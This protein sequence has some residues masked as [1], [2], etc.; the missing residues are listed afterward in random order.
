MYR[1]RQRNKGEAGYDLMKDGIEFED[2]KYSALVQRVQNGV[3]AGQRLAVEA[4]EGVEELVVD[5]DTHRTILFR[6]DYHWRGPW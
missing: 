6:Y 1:R 2:G 3:Y 4:D 5:G